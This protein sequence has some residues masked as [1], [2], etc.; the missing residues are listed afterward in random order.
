MNQ[1]RQTASRLT[2]DQG[3][4]FSRHVDLISI[5]SQVFLRK[6]IACAA[7]CAWL[8][9]GFACPAWAGLSSAGTPAK[10]ASEEL[11]Q[12]GGP[13]SVGGT[14]NQDQKTEAAMPRHPGPLEAYFAF[15]EKVQKEYGLA[16]G[17]DYN[18]LFQA[19]SQSPGS[20]TAA[21][22]ALR[23]FGQWT[24]LGRESENTGALVY[25]VENRHRLGAN[26]APKDLGFEIGYAGLTAV[27]FSSI[28]WALTNLYWNQHLLDNRVAFVAGVLDVTDYMDVY[29]MVDPWTAFSNLAFTTNPTIAVPNQ[30]LGAALRV[31][32][33]DNYYVLG[34]IADA[35]GDPT[36]PGNSFSSF[37][38]DA[39]YFTHLEV[40]WAFSYAKRFS[41]NIH[42]TAWHAERRESAQ[43]SSGWGM[44][45]SFSRLFLEK[46]EPFFRAGYAQDGG[47]LW[48]RSLS[49]GLGYYFKASGNLL[50]VGFNWS[51]PSE[52]TL[53]PGLDDQYTAEVFYRLQLL[54]I[55]TITPDLQ[56]LVDP[57]LNPDQDVMAVFGVRARIIF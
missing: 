24:I 27:P 40:G 15:K 39:E 37:F 57:A 11:P 30:G 47:S 51:R 10:P 26:I 16:F 35:N 50:G 6:T 20:D 48:E 14:L 22:G 41:D 5:I 8:L 1:S 46:W 25:K 36:D 43:V 32:I 21:G 49:L 23:M 55:L 9:L 17:F 56:V 19:A 31:T 38:G 7:C 12:F 33:A 13:G 54:E 18:L 34:G 44:A 42:L 52:D 4:S 28:G 53:G 45:F 2:A 29:S 3:G